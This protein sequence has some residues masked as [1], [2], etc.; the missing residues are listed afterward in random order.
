MRRGDHPAEDL[1]PVLD[2][3]E[4]ETRVRVRLTVMAWR[5]GWAELVKT[6]LHGHGPDVSEIGSTWIGNL[7]AM[8]ALR[9]FDLAEIYKL[10]GEKAFLPAS[11]QSGLVRDDATLYAIPWLADTRLIYYHPHALEKAG[12][13]AS[14]AFSSPAQ[15]STTLQR[16]Q[17]SGLVPWSM[18]TATPRRVLHEAAS[19][20]WD[21]GGDFISADGKRVLFDEPEARAG[22]RSYFELGRYLSPTVYRLN[23]TRA[24]ELFLREQAAAMLSMPM[25]YVLQRRAHPETARAWGV[26]SVLSTPFVGGSNLVIWRH[27][28]QGQNALK[29]IRWLTTPAAQNAYNMFSGLLPVRV[30]SLM[31][32]DFVSDPNLARI[33]QGLR[34]GRSFP[35]IRLWGLIEDKLAGALGQIWEEIFNSAVPENDGLFDKYLT[36][37]AKQLNRTL[38]GV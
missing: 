16:L 11:W 32:P 15:L 25:A 13:D 17:A 10:G 28:R 24:D 29:L 14:T 23:G 6:A 38:L 2:R 19:W 37:L 12:L 5:E 3:F 20:V 30:E 21:A 36:P 4:A 34:Q 35:A 18:C 1:Q 26:T 31:A 9:P 8:N 27:S 7:V 22:L 33:A